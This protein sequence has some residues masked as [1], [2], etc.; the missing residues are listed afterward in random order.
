M[1]GSS[2]RRIVAIAVWVPLAVG[3]VITGVWVHA[4]QLRSRTIAL[5]LARRSGQQLLE[6]V[7]Q[8]LG[9]LTNR[10]EVVGDVLIGPR[11]SLANLPSVMVPVLDNFVAHQP[12]FVGIG[13]VDPRGRTVWWE[14]GGGV[15]PLAPAAN[16]I[17]QPTRVHDGLELGVPIRDPRTSRID[18]LVEGVVRPATLLAG[19]DLRSPRANQLV[20]GEVHLLAGGRAAVIERAKSPVGPVLVGVQPEGLP[21]LATNATLAGLLGV[22]AALLVVSV[23][24]WRFVG[25]SERAR[26]ELAW[27]GELE[28]ALADLAELAARAES[29]Q[30]FL[31]MAAGRLRQI[32]GVEATA[33]PVQDH[34]EIAARHP[35]VTRWLAAAEPRIAATVARERDGITLV[36]RLRDAQA[37]ARAASERDPLTGLANRLA[38]TAR[39]GQLGADGAATT[40]VLCMV[41]DL[42]GF[43]EVNDSLGHVAGDAVLVE[44]ARRVR[45]TAANHAPGSLVARFGGDEF[46]VLAELEAEGASAERMARA[47]A[48]VVRQPVDLGNGSSAT[49]EASIGWAWWPRDAVDP[50]EL[51]Q[52]ADRTMYEAKRQRAQLV[53]GTRASGPSIAPWSLAAE[54]LLEEDP[55][56]R[57]ALDGLVAVEV[58]GAIRRGPLE[59]ARALRDHPWGAVFPAPC[60]VVDAT[61]VAL[62]RLESAQSV[63]ETRL[64]AL[65]VRWELASSVLDGRPRTSLSDEL[66]WVG[67]QPGIAA[68]AV[69]ERVRT[70]SWRVRAIRGQERDLLVHA[71]EDPASQLVRELEG[72]GESSADLGRFVV[73]HAPG[74]A[75]A[76]VVVLEAACDREVDAL[77]RVLAA[78]HQRLGLVRRDVG[79]TIA[80]REVLTLLRGGRLRLAYQPILRLDDGSVVAVE[81]L[82]RLE[83]SDGTLLAPGLFLP[84]LERDELTELFSQVLELALGFAE[85]CLRGDVG[86]GVNVPVSVLAHGGIDV[87]RGALQRHALAPRRL[88]LE[89]LEHPSADEPALAAALEALDELGVRLS[90]DD[91]G[92]GVQGVARLARLPVH[93]VKGSA[94]LVH[95]L[96]ER[97]LAT[98]ATLWSLVY[99]SCA[100]GRDVVLEGIESQAALEVAIALGV[101]LGQGFLLG[102]PSL[103]LRAPDAPGAIRRARRLTTLEGMLAWHWVHRER[104]H[105][106]ELE[107]CPLTGTLPKTLVGLHTEVHRRASLEASEM[108]TQALVTLLEDR[109][110]RES[111]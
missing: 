101:G 74:A 97:P 85:S 9:E 60:P 71:L 94:I 49:V 37:H 96:E 3:L 105:G 66:A 102:R 62:A 2:W 99:A 75:W 38:L 33:S 73:V 32:H 79:G 39:L 82:A 29:E 12:E 53:A 21:V 47:I 19:L 27:H 26:R 86:V 63:V 55:S 35:E 108:L 57:A 104:G 52:A 56:W 77:G 81:A 65:A 54:R 59:L 93:E 69:C 13:V 109:R 31:A 98:I 40:S 22:D 1:L 8:R 68:V 25:A 89:I 41:V 78:V 42:D 7:V 45:T 5:S 10:L 70:G 34:L 24:L 16:A 61:G 83:R 44:V 43:K 92:S 51:V 107:R 23:V 76:L 46:V 106:I 84:A 90:L 111:A 100:L 48:R 50:R 103:Q 36:R 14:S 91:V 87:V 110:G 18:F 4:S 88:T 80:R 64:R 6:S 11:P 95:T 58:L 72:I 30:A 67:A 15:V 17:V 28:A 20:V